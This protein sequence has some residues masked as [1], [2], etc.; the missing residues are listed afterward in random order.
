[1][2]AEAVPIIAV[3][4]GLEHEEDLDGRRAVLRKSLKGYKMVPKNV[5]CIVST[6]GRKGEHKE[7]Y[8]VSQAQL[9][10]L[11]TTSH[12]KKAWTTND[13]I[14]QIYTTTYSTKF[15]LLP[16]EQV[17]FVEQA[18]NVVDVF[19]KET[20]MKPEDSKR[21]KS[22]LLEAEKKLKKKKNFLGM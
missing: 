6:Q 13:W 15:C 4:T 19:I 18:G 8:D 12:R 5:A 10:Q 22:T 2:C 17:N 1:L 20:G 7:Q 9:R 3:E 21:L 16:E 11:I 14:G